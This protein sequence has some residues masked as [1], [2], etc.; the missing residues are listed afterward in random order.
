MQGVVQRRHRRERQGRHQ[1]QHGLRR[2]H[3][4]PRRRVAARGTPDRRCAA[5]ATGISVCVLGLDDKSHLARTYGGSIGKAPD[6][7]PLTRFARLSVIDEDVL[8]LAIRDGMAAD[9]SM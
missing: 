5:N 6:H 3:H 8:H 4:R 9:R 2:P 7:G 1:P